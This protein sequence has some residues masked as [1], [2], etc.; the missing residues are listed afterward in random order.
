MLLEI[1]TVQRNHR[2]A[3]LRDGVFVQALQPGRHWVWTWGVT[4]TVDIDITADLLALDES[5]PLPIDLEGTRIVTVLPG[6]VVI[7]KLG[8]RVRQVLEVGHYRVWEGAG[9][10]EE[11]VTIDLLA[12]PQALLPSDV[13][14]PTLGLWAEVSASRRTA[15]VLHQ[16]GEPV[17]V[18]R[19]GRYRLWRKSPWS[20][21]AVPLA[22]R[23]LDVAAQDVVTRDQIPVRVK[24]AAT[25]RVVDPMVRVSEPEGPDQA[26]GAVQQALREV[27]ASRDFDALVSDRDALSDELLAR[28][29]TVLP[30]LGL[31]LER[32][33]IKDIIL[34]GE[35]K[36]MV[37]RVTMA[38]KEA[39]A[40][41]I[42]RREE[43]AATRQMANTAK[44]LEQNPIL[45]RLKE[46]EAIGEIVGKIDKLVVVGGQD[47]TRQVLL[48]ESTL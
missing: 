36:A 1:L 41:G 46:L 12:E 28:A 24:P 38:R 4:E 45:L 47:L 14:E 7:R 3:V 11:R 19:D 48:R 35:V 37:N 27:I 44:L 42:K 29:R 31:V 5:D 15:L 25:Y 34:P 32:V 9:Y 2:T 26:Y 6:Q 18:L 22:L 39:E 40:Y 8:G 20:V 17:G 13:L 10:D 16:D 21:I 33:W 23:S 30:H 43:V